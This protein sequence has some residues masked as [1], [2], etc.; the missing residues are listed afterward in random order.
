MDTEAEEKSGSSKMERKER[1][2]VSSGSEKAESEKALTQSV[3]S[4]TPGRGFC[5]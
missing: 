1:K 3:G 5:G 2:T 4:E